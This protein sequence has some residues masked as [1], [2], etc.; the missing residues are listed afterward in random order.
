[1]KNPEPV[2]KDEVSLEIKRDAPRKEEKP[3]GVNQDRLC[4]SRIMISSLDLRND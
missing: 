3:Q 1:M 2:R 4:D